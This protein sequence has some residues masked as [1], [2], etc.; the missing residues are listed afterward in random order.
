MFIGTCYQDFDYKMLW[1]DVMIIDV[2]FF[3][4]L[5]KLSLI[6][7]ETELTVENM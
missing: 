6:I 1:A 2:Y 4:A 7:E 5:P 3:K